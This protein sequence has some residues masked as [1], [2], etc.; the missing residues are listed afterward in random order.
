MAVQILSITIYCRILNTGWNNQKRNSFL[1]LLLK[2]CNICIPEILYIGIS[3]LKIFFLIDIN[4]LSS[5]TLVLVFNLNLQL[6][7]ILFVVH[8]LTWHHKLYQ[9]EII[10]LFIPICGLLVFYTMWCSKEIILSEQKVK[11]NYLKKS[12]KVNLNTSTMI[13]PIRA[14]SWLNHCSV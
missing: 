11:A 13:F 4:I 2:L 1:R 3:K 7:L 9:K 12:V 10:S 5:L 8:P 6:L 14:K